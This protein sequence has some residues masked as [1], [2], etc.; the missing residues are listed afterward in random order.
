MARRTQLLSL[1]LVACCTLLVHRAATM[2]FTTP[3]S[4]SNLRKGVAM[5][6]AK[7]KKEIPEGMIKVEDA[8]KILTRDK[9]NNPPRIATSLEN[10][11]GETWTLSTGASNEVHYITPNMDT[12]LFGQWLSLAPN[13]IGIITLFTVG[14][15]IEI[16]RFFPDAMYW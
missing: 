4:Q 13:F 7:K 1:V 8:G 15:M 14:M 12:E 6:A 11:W 2:L 10:V 3:S 16:Q 9:N 5:Q